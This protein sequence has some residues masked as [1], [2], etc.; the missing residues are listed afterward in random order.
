MV[1][2][3]PEQSV[4]EQEIP[5]LAAVVVEDERVPIRVQALA[6][7]GMLVEVRSVEKPQ[8]VFVAGK[9]RGNRSR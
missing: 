5:N 3:Q 1:E 2:V 9:V 4:A 7:V 6:A 8:A